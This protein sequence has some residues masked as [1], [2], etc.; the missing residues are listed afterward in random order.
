[1][2]R[3]NPPLGPSS[4]SVFVP[5]QLVVHMKRI[6]HASR[7]GATNDNVS[8][9]VAR[10]CCGALSSVDMRPRAFVAL[11]RGN[12]TIVTN[13]LVSGASVCSV[14]N[15]L[16]RRA[17]R[18]KISRYVARRSRDRGD[19]FYLTKLPAAKLYSVDGRLTTDE[20]RP[21]VE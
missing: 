8:L 17:P 1:M 5:P 15:T 18:W 14:T 10:Q 6:H 2:V 3:V 19:V 4:T 21:W 12:T 9:G 20:R 16:G 7:N 13:G 11:P